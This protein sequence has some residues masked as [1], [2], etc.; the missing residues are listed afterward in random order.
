MMD[1]YAASDVFVCRSNQLSYL[2]TYQK[3]RSRTAD[4]QISVNLMLSTHLNKN[5]QSH[6]ISQIP[7]SVPSRGRLRHDSSKIPQYPYFLLE[8]WVSIQVLL[9]LAHLL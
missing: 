2:L 3:G 5:N 9:K 4:P 8:I 7:I 1:N 6:A